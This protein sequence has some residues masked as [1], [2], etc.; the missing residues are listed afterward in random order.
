MHSFPPL[1]IIFGKSLLTQDILSEEGSIRKTVVYEFVDETQ[2]GE[3]KQ[4][5][6]WEYVRPH[7]LQR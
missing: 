2:L 5:F 1:L 7:E 6:L 3:L 4:I